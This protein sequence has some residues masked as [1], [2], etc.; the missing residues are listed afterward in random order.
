MEPEPDGDVSA[1]QPKGRPGISNDLPGRFLRP[2]EGGGDSFFAPPFAFPLNG[3]I[4]MRLSF[5][6]LR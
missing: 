3:K 6:R 2:A 1:N 4:V 5:F